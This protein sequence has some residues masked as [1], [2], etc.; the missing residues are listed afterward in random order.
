MQRN[1]P[2]DIAVIPRDKRDAESGLQRHDSENRKSRG[3][4][5]CNASEHC[6]LVQNHLESGEA[7]WLE[8]S[9]GRITKQDE[10]SI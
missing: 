2:R 3:L 4:L 9:E 7:G 5:L 6:K 8:G 10:D 1:L